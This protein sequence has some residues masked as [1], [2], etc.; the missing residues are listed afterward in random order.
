MMRHGPQRVL[1][2]ELPPQHERGGEREREREV[3]EAPRVEH[4]RGDHRR[5][6][7]P[8]RDLRQHRRHRLERVGL[9]ARSALRRA[10]GAG[11]EDH[12]ATLLRWGLALGRV[13]AR[14]QVLEQRIAAGPI[15]LVPG[16]EP[17]AALRARVHEVLELI[18]VDDGGGLLARHDFCELWSREGGVQVQGARPQLRACHRRIYEAP[19]VA[20][21]D[22]HSVAF[23]DPRVREPRRERVRA[24]LH[25]GERERP[26]IVDERRPVRVADRSAGVGGGRR[27]A[28]A[29]QGG[30]GAHRLVGPRRLEHAGGEQ[31]PR[32]VRFVEHLLREEL[33]AHAGRSLT[34][35]ITAW[36]ARPV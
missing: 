21:H 1:G 19:V 11:R 20:A 4:R 29:P 27:G 6:L 14:D 18:V 8:Q 32:H 26:A 13:S 31:R 10:G 33:R 12:N 34:R 22:R 7:G 3:C 16:D 25:L 24:Q 5:A 15:G 17:L 9:L 35:S 30:G 28:P 2:V 36:P 23:A